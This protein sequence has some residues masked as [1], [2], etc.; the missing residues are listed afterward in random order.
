M[1]VLRSLLYKLILFT[2][3]LILLLFGNDED[4]AGSSFETDWP[5]VYRNGDQIPTNVMPCIVWRRF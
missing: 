1:I 2:S 3:R 4:V 5:Y